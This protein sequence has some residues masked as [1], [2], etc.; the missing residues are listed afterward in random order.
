MRR[1]LVA[2]PGARA[3][4]AGGSRPSAGLARSGLRAWS[5]SVLRASDGAFRRAAI[6]ARKPRPDRDRAGWGSVPSPPMA[7]AQRRCKQGSVGP[8]AA[9]A[10]G[11][12]LALIA[13]F[14]VIQGS[15]GIDDGVARTP[16]RRRRRGRR[17]RRRGRRRRD[18]EDVHGR[19]GRHAE[20]D[21][22]E[23]R[24]QRRSGSS[25]STRTSIR[26]TLNAGQEIKIR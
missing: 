20:R 8:A 17:A 18:T 21:R 9:R 25:G 13:L 10:A 7:E 24:R 15:L 3:G 1:I 12:V 6:T 4:R 5:R 22:R 14:V 26:Q 2:G 23:V 16:A 19:G 11:L